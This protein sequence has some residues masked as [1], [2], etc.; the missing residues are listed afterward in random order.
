MNSNKV[1]SDFLVIGSGIAGL[2]FA[3][4]A[5]SLGTVNIVTK[6]KEFDSNTNYAQGGIAS[7]LAPDDSFDSH[8]EDTLRSGAGLCNRKSVEFL[9]QNGPDRINELIEWGTRF[10]LKEKHRDIEV[11]DL[12]REGGHSH[13]RIVHATDLTGREIERALLNK[14]SEIPNIQIYE[15][16]TAVDL[17]TEHQLARSVGNYRRKKSKKTHCYGAYIL[18]NR[19]GAV[20]IFNAKITFLATGGVGQVY[21]HTTNPDI[22]TGDGIAM[23]YR[24]GALISDMEFIQF[25][26]TTLYSQNPGGRSFLI[27]EAVRGEGAVL[28]NSRGEHFMDTIHPLKDLAPRDIVAR[29]IDSE[30]KRLGDSFVYLDITS[31]GRHF[32]Q[33]RFPHIYNRCLDE[34]IDISKDAIPVVPAAHYLCG[35]I[36]SDIHGRTSI[37]NLFVSGESACTGVHGANRLASNSLLEGI[38]FSHSAFT[39]LKEHYASLKNS[40][41]IPEYPAW[42]REGTFDFNEWILVKHD[43]EDIKRLMWDYVGIVRSDLRLNRA[44]NR[45]LFLAE[46]VHSY[47]QKSIISSRVIELRNL[48]TV[49]KLVIKSAMMRKDSIGLHY[50]TDHP[51]KD[52]YIANIVLRSEHEPRF[53]RIDRQNPIDRRWIRFTPEKKKR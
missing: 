13:N 23:A 39:Y 43:I 14:I 18:N 27:S 35:G 15:D 4:K 37:E 47:Y 45:I 29:A 16:H 34:G 10:S 7:V 6:K 12:G 25:H 42:N 20:K 31:K 17:L 11:L 21:L 33:K 50:N 28:I 44:Y 9:V 32:L 5:S 1:E 36:I 3:I 22:A 38:V 49:A 8:V 53:I 24:A 2:T 52:E 51:E 41:R 40:I 26:P 48:A 30:L 19:T 46:E